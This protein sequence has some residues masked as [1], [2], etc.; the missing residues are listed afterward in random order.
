M[1]KSQEQGRPCLLAFNLLNDLRGRKKQ[2]TPE[3]LNGLERENA[4]AV[5]L[6][7]QI[8]E[9]DCRTAIACIV[10]AFSRDIEASRRGYK[11]KKES[12]QK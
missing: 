4:E 10:N 6:F 9:C 2:L 8:A 5:A 12:G 7:C 1:A 11:I 3:Q